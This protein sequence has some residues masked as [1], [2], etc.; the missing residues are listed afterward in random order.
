MPSS[1][2][3]QKARRLCEGRPPRPRLQF[4][5]RPDSII[6]IGD[7]HGC[8][9]KQKEM[10]ALILAECRAEDGRTMIIY[11]GDLVDRGPD[12]AGVVAHCQSP[13]PNGVERLSLCGNH[14]Q[15]FLDFLTEPTLATDWLQFGGRETLRSYDVDVEDPAIT[16]MDEAALANHVRMVIPARDLAFLNAL[17]AAISMPGLIFVH[18]GMRIGVPIEKQD[19]FDLMWI[20]EDFLVEE[21]ASDSLVIHGHTPAPHPRLGTGRIG[22]D[23][24]AV[25]GGPLTALHITASGE[26]RFLQV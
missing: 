18:A 7:V 13:L 2:F 15:A 21:R 12:S 1:H 4:E 17:P 5:S 24:K 23:T 16:Q 19:E 9:E 3:A 10:E 6:A 8:L 25:G 11:L 14:D 26:H 20:R 22:V